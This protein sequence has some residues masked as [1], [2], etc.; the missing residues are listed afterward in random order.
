MA[1]KTFNPSVAS[2]ELQQT[3]SFDPDVARSGYR[4]RE[5]LLAGAF[6][7]FFLMTAIY[8]CLAVGAWVA[9]L[10]GWLRLP[11][12]MS[13]VY[14]HAHEMLFGF[15]PAAI[16]GFLLTAMPNWTGAAPLSGTRLLALI[17]LWLAGRLAMTFSGD[18]PLPLVAALDLAFLP[19]LASY[20]FL[21]LRR[22]GN[23][24]NYP[25]ALVLGFMAFCNLLMHLTFMKILPA[26]V[27]QVAIYADLDLICVVMVIIAGR[28]VP[29]FTMN[30]LR[31][32]Q[33]DPRVVRL[34][35][36][37]ERLAVPVTVALAPA[38][39]LVNHTWLA[40]VIAFLAAAVHGL[41]LY[42]WRGWH[43]RREPLLWILHVGY[44]WIVL[45]LLLKGL[46]AFT[47]DV[48]AAAWIH[49]LGVGG[50][51]T[52][53][54]GVMTRVAVGHTGRA[55]RL[56]RGGLVIYGAVLAAGL[57]RVAI[58]LGIPLYG[59][60]TYPLIAVCWVAAFGLFAALYWP[61]LSR[62]RVDGRP[63]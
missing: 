49:A 31:V 4:R 5:V 29:T 51:A 25:L 34:L 47:A 21:V 48:G 19:V 39:L 7:S 8:A 63:G 14:W 6:R 55:L 1:V 40:G 50:A 12:G 30:W 52:L 13:P 36:W 17:S 44:G 45:A 54:L 18:L 28:I 3:S 46:A 41:R 33:G 43:A 23:R 59:V 10:F 35:P 15:V 16:A 27:D 42:H 56:R 11:L 2:T 9:V 24:R 26:P 58:A 61:V 57:A 60:W 38:D 32:N 62:P 20:A 37:V 22:H 53:I